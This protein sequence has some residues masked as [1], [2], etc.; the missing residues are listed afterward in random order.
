VLREE[1]L[2]SRGCLFAVI[3]SSMSYG[4]R[5]FNPGVKFSY[6]FGE[7]GGY[8]FG[9]EMSYTFAS[10]GFDG[11]AGIVLSQDLCFPAQR[12]KT[13]VGVEYIPAP[14]LMGLQVGPSFL[15]E[16]KTSSW[17][18]TMTVF[19]GAF[20]LPSVAVTIPVENAVLFEAGSF[21]E[22]HVPIEKMSFH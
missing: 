1:T 22:I 10:R 8:T 18:F 17:G 15:N 6:T 14:P 16:G 12:N 13:H 11:Y 20:L 19:G 9:V 7:Q 4:Q 21:L 2:V 5:F 3:V